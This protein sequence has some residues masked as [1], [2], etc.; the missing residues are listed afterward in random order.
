[1][2][3]EHDRAKV[4]KATWVRRE[5]AAKERRRSARA[6]GVAS[7]VIMGSSGESSF[8]AGFR[9]G[10]GWEGETA[11]WIEDSAPVNGVV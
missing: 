2:S 6:A 7:I 10:R 3:E 9:G 11:A 4:G 8:F 5:G 1:M